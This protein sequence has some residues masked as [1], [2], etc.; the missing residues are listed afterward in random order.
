MVDKIT[1]N[2]SRVQYKTA[3]LNGITYS[4]MLA[5]PQG[6]PLHTIF[7]IHG[8]PDISLGWRYQIPH[9]VSLG[10]RVVVPDMM[11]YA[12]TDAPDSPTFYTCKRAADDMAELAKQL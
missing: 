10:L 5:E 1:P 9:L 2:D 6:H 3:N 12:G 11:G 8:W 4:Y 7:L